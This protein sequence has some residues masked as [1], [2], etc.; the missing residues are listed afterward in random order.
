MKQDENAHPRPT[1]MRGGG[2][3]HC[4]DLHCISLLFAA[5]IITVTVCMS[6]HYVM[7]N[8]S[9]RSVHHSP[10]SIL[11]TLYPIP[12]TIIG[13][14]SASLTLSMATFSTIGVSTRYASHPPANVMVRVSVL[15]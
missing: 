6:Y 10:C 5:H 1:G 4:Y 15:G 14:A 13:L 8:M 3:T 12:H 9:L 7:H 2:N 11:H